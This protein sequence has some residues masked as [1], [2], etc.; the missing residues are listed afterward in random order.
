MPAMKSLLTAGAALLASGALAQVPAE[1][2]AKPPADAARYIISS[3]AGQHGESWMWTAPDGKRM[4]RESLLL[5]GQLWEVDSA[6]TDDPIDPPSAITIR[7]VT[8]MGDAAETFSLARNGTAA[9]KSP[10]DEGSAKVTG[11][12]F[13][14]AQGGPVALMA[15]FVQHVLAQPDKTLDL[16]PGG[17]AQAEKLTTIEIGEG[18]RRKTV[19]A[20]AISGLSNEPVPVWTDA[21]G[22]FFGYVASL[23]WLPEGYQGERA[24][25]DEAQTRALARRMPAIAA[26]LVTVP[27]GPVAFTKVRIYDANN[28]TFLTDQTVLVSGTRIIA[29]GGTGT[30]KVPADAQIIDGAGKTLVPGLWD[31][32]MHLAGDYEALQE[33]SLGVTS[34]R[35]PGNNDAL[36]IDRRERAA[37][38]ELL[39]PNVYA[40]SLIDGRGPNTAQV[41]NV[42]ET[43]EQ[44]IVL[45]RE[46]KE[47]GFSGVK[48]YG[49]L[50]PAWLPVMI[51]QA[52]QLGLHVH[53]HIPQGMRPMQAIELGYDE[54]THINW[55]MMQA[56]PDE[57]IAASNGLARFEGP[58]RYGKD[59]DLNGPVM[60]DMIH[61]MAG[62]KIA[63]DPTAVAFE[64]LYVPEPGEIAGAYAPFVGTLPIA[65]E[66]GFR[67]GGFAVPP[68]VSRA[69]YRKSFTNMLVLI[70]K[71]FNA[72]VPIVAG[73]DGSGIELVRELELYVAAG[74]TPAQALSTATI[75][76]ARL[77][78]VDAEVGSISAGKMAD[79]VLVEGD[80]GKNIA[81]LRQ[82]RLVMMGGRLMDADKLRA[83][84]GFSGRPR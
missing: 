19:V 84:A 33:L 73:T 40:S 2:L 39:L 36:T 81:A 24:R 80:P 27:T 75:Q 74:L 46:A 7:G 64:G 76:P 63:S 21:D 13:Y 52:H 17:K 82:T 67:S 28:M 1:Q 72:G 49:S 4:G 45:V 70:R 61:A 47:K 20:W 8:P 51:A 56:M 31:A 58:G 10:V 29:V 25:L 5:R 50:D 62:R 14:Y 35:D 11:P 18:D 48:F 71:M 53:G 12:R 79:L 34:I 15:S 60:S 69:D 77:V 22:R 83:A 16:L 55:V 3:P 37:R 66:R 32:H 23:G 43:E 42:A 44:A 41:A 54:I 65:V 9:W 59:V 78:G 68:G 26:S 30:V 38:G 57:V 6:E